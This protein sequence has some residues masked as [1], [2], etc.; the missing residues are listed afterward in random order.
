[1][2][3]ASV[4]S[5]EDSFMMQ[6]RATVRDEASKR[7]NFLLSFFAFSTITLIIQKRF[8]GLSNVLCFCQIWRCAFTNDYPLNAFKKSHFDSILQSL[9]WMISRQW[10]TSQKQY[11]CASFKHSKIWYTIDALN[12]VI[13]ILTILDSFTVV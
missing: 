1:M 11:N 7:G 13:A 12:A 5:F 6:F 10:S 3:K 8:K 9:N 2:P 4:C